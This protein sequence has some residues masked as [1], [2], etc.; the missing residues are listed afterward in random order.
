MTT[1]E[2]KLDLEY[3]KGET[4]C[5]KTFYLR[6]AENKSEVGRVFGWREIQQ[7][8]YCVCI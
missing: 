6:E 1:E 3:G 2:L 4:G 7:V 8:K 5:Q